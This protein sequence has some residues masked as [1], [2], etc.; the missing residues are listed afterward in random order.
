MVHR[1]GIGA[2]LAASVIFAVILVSGFGVYAASQ[3]RESLYSTADSANYLGS[4]FLALEGAAGVNVLWQLQQ[5]V[6]STPIA[7]D[8]P[9]RAVGAFLAGLTE[10]EA[11][12]NVSLTATASLGEDV[13]ATDN[14][15]TLGPYGGSLPGSLDV[16]ISY[17]GTGSEGAGV[18]LSRM[19]DHFAHLGV[20]FASGPSVCLSSIAAIATS[21]E[22]LTVENCTP[23][24]IGYLVERAAAPA[25]SAAA[26]AGFALSYAYSAASGSGCSVSFRVDLA[27][28]GI[29][30]PGG[31]FSVAFEGRG[32]AV[33]QLS[34]SRPP[35]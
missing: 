13:L 20:D 4:E 1:A 12:A 23:P 24:S 31:A 32:S 26:R 29:E 30:G 34:A 5:F 11:A 28:S 22:G 9:G 17:V 21:L 33:L 2:T 6:S 15:S 18:L 16:R 3:G 7:C 10:R 19:E 35:G 27:Q 14:L 8:S 25:T